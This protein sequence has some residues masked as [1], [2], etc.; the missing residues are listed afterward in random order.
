MKKRTVA[1]YL[2]FLPALLAIAA[3]IYGESTLGF[4]DGTFAL[5]IVIAL[6]SGVALTVVTFLAGW[7]FLPILTTAAYALGFGLTV[8]KAAPT[9]SD[10]FNGVNFM[11]GNLENC[12][13]YIILTGLAL[14]ISMVLL[15]LPERRQ[16]KA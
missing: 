8:S 9:L 15:F 2:S 4:N 1:A 14:V 5:P 12:V 13:V 3:V 16:A 6:A 7:D 11:G 10:Y